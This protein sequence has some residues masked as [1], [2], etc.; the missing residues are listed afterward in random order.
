MSTT[1]RAGRVLVVGGTVAQVQEDV[2]AA[3]VGGA[4]VGVKLAGEGFDV[5]AGFGDLVGGEVV[6]AEV[7]GAVVVAERRHRP[8]PYLLFVPLSG[9]VGVGGDPQPPDPGPQLTRRQL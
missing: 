7:G 9:G 1:P 3:L 8:F 4:F 6:A 5:G 2:D